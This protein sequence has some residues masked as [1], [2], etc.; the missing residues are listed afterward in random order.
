MH[1]GVEL[2]II[3][4]SSTAAKTAAV[5]HDLVLLCGPH[6]ESSQVSGTQVAVMAVLVAAAAPEFRWRHF[7]NRVNASFLGRERKEGAG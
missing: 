1:F 5:L 3:S 7:V 6:S 2:C 4:S